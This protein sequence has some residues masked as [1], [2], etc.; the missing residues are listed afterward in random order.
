M[1]IEIREIVF[2]SPELTAAI[3]D[4]YHRLSSHKDHEILKVMVTEN[5][6]TPVNLSVYNKSLDQRVAEVLSRAEVG[7]AL[8]TYC[9]RTGVMMSRQS[10]KS[11]GIKDGQIILKLRLVSG[12]SA[13][14]SP[15]S[16][17]GT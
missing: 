17:L 1:P 14:N 3:T 4:F 16:S 8:I 15:L 6:E 9:R 11:V 5:S 12:Q 10:R 2:S 7:A 13:E